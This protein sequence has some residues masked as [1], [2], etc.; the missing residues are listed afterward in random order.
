M[1]FSASPISC[2]KP[3]FEHLCDAGMSP[4]QVFHFLARLL[5][6][7]LCR[8]PAADWHALS[9]SRTLLEDYA[10]LQH[11]LA[12]ATEM[13]DIFANTDAWSEVTLLKNAITAINALDWVNIRQYGAG[14]VF[15]YFLSEFAPQHPLRL[16]PPDLA[17]ILAGLLQ[18]EPG[19]AVVDPFTACGTLLSAAHGFR[20]ALLQEDPATY[21]TRQ[22]SHDNGLYGLERDATY[23]KLAR[24]NFYL[25]DMPAHLDENASLPQADV[26]LSNILQNVEDETA[27]CGTELEAW[28]TCLSGMKTGGRGMLL[29]NDAALDT[30]AGQVRR[31]ALLARCEVHTILRLPDG[32]FYGEDLSAHAVFFTAGQVTRQTWIYDLRTGL[33]WFDP[34][35]LP[36]QA[37]Y[38][39]PFIDAFGEQPDG[40][41]KRKDGGENGRFRC[42]QRHELDDNNLLPQWLNEDNDEFPFYRA[43][44]PLASS[45]EEDSEMVTEA[46]DDL[47]SLRDLLSLT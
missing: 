47:Q 24:M 45:S 3:L 2:L 11:T 22:F 42:F 40:S 34:E 25:Q 27:L 13:K 28:E 26:L 30:P 16:S 9:G 20:L 29:L 6:I 1:N 21:L 35:H 18:P 17:T 14:E 32:F 41:G 4:A 5:F 44:H 39:N 33:P 37:H 7:K 8:L 31:G 23:R 38:F 43:P 36:F 10:R 19:E 46:L 12:Q 15:E